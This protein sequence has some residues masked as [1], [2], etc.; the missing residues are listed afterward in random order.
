MRL[1]VSGAVVGDRIVRGDVEVAAGVVQAVGVGAPRG[2]WLAVP[3]FVDL[4]VNGFAGVDFLT[5]HAAGHARAREALLQTGVTAYQPTL[6]TASEPALTAALGEIGGL[7]PNPPSGARVLGAHVE[8]PFLSPLWMGSHPGR[9]RRDPDEALLDR[10]LA[11]GP[12]SHLT[13]APELPGAT[14]LVR[15]LVSRGVVVACGHTDARAVEAD[16]AFDLGARTV[17][18]LFNAM[19]RL[20]PRDPGIAGAALARG[21]VTVQ[22]IADGHHLADETVL[23]VWRAAR[24]RLALVTDAVAA[25]ACG[26]GRY[27]LGDVEVEV[28]EGAVR[29]ADGRLAGSALTMIEAVRNLHA[30]G[31]PL[32]ECV[33]A[34]STLPAR[35]A[36]R[37]DLGM[38]GAGRA[39]DLVV[40][41]DRLEIRDVLRGPDLR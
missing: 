37:P 38:L 17:T 39:A 28:R 12:V 1:G 21:D 5:A 31:V 14:A 29:R 24:G 3:G 2:S 32:P 11:A 18:H 7:S 4:Q 9:W 19:R 34:A 41:D 6:I 20:E 16:A 22:I 25:A 33:A 15:R 27:R 10:L 13:L 36:Q 35:I 8:G 26:D 23:L 40:L 30:L